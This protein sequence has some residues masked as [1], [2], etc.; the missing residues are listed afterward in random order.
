MTC[1]NSLLGYWNE[2]WFVH[3]WVGRNRGAWTTGNSPLTKAINGCERGRD[4]ALVE[5]VGNLAVSPM[6][7]AQSEYGFAVRFQFAARP[8]RRFIFSLLLQIHFVV[9]PFVL[10]R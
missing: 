8:A 5:P 3:G 7:T 10:A 4:A 6:L 9:W 1:V 2:I